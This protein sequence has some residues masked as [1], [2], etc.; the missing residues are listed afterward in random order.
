MFSTPILEDRIKVSTNGHQLT[1]TTRSDQRQLKL[2]AC[3]FY[4]GLYTEVP[5]GKVTAS[6]SRHP[7]VGKDALKHKGPLYVERAFEI[8]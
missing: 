1:V 4:G 6:H 8:K 3:T 5:Q 7:Q 2:S